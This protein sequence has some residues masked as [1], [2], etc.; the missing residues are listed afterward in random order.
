MDPVFDDES[1]DI[2]K[3]LAA[4]SDRFIMVAY[5]DASFAVDETKQSIS[6]FVVMINGISILW[7]SLKQKI[8]VDST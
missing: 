6:G 3:K 8:V 7:G 4:T 5:S 1:L 2:E